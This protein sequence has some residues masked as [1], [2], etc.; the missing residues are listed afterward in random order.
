MRQHTKPS[1]PAAPPGDIARETLC[2]ILSLAHWEPRGRLE[3]C[4]R[5]EPWG[6]VQPWGRF[7]LKLEPWERAQ[8][9]G[10]LEQNL[11]PNL[12]PWGVEPRG[13]ERGYC[14]AHSALLESPG[15]TSAS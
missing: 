13:R 15:W 12:E 1:E 5:V 9:W 2:K 11:E 14:L 4:D 8:P 7:E 6:R 3:P 10:R